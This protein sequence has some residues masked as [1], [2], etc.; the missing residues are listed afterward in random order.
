RRIGFYISFAGNVTYPSATRLRETAARVSAEALLVETDCP[1]LAPKS[2]RG[3]TNE[4]AFARETAEELARVYGLTVAD[5]ERVSSFNAFHLFGVGSA[6]DPGTVVYPIRDGLYVNLTNRCTNRCVFCARETR[7][8]VK[9]HNLA[10]E[11]EPSAERVTAAIGDPRMYKEI[12][13]CGFGEP[14]LR[15]DALKA[16]AAWVKR[17]S[18]RTKVRINTNGHASLIHGRPVCAELKGLVD[19]VSVSLN[20]ADRDSYARLC[21][22]EHGPE[23]FDALLAFVREAKAALPEVVVTAIDMPGVDI[24]ACQRL[25]AELGVALRVR[26]YDD[27]GTPK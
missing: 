6:A 12:V 16:V 22:P 26:K 25:A 14:T 1:Y 8:V 4:P 19:S 5:V 2:R 15:L 7:P 23:A 9:G 3:Q 27:V 18:P 24:P 13:F 11:A 17:T 21:Q 20:A 10:L